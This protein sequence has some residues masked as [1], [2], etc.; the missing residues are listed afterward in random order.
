MGINSSAMTA[1]TN[2]NE[3]IIVDLDNNKIF[4][5]NCPIQLPD[6]EE[7][8]LR[9]KLRQHAYSHIYNIDFID[10]NHGVINLNE[11]NSMQDK[12]IRISFFLLWS[13]LLGNY[14]RYYTDDALDRI[15]F[16]ADQPKLKQP[17]LKS[18]L[19]TQAF[20]QFESS[21]NPLL[22]DLLK[23]SMH[24][25]D[26]Q[27]QY[28]MGKFHN[29]VP[30]AELSKPKKLQAHPVSYEGSFPK[31]G[32]ESEKACNYE[33]LIARLSGLITSEPTRLEYRA[34]RALYLISSGQILPSLP[35]IE[36]VLELNERF[37]FQTEV[38]DGLVKVFEEFEANPEFYANNKA[39]A[40]SVGERVRR[41]LKDYQVAKAITRKRSGSIS[42]SENLK[43]EDSMSID[44][45]FPA[46]KEIDPLNLLEDLMLPPK[47]NMNLQEFTKYCKDT[48]CYKA[49][50]ATKLFD[51]LSNGKST[52]NVERL[53]K[54]LQEIQRRTL[55]LREESVIDTREVAYKVSNVSNAGGE[56]GTLIITNLR[57]IFVLASNSK[58]LKKP[59]LTIKHERIINV[60]KFNFV[61]II[62]PGVPCIRIHYSS[63]KSSQMEKTTFCILSGRNMWAKI[64]REISVGH[65][66]ARDTYNAKVMK[67]VFHRL[68]LTDALEMITKKPTKALLVYDKGS[69]QFLNIKRILDE[70]GPLNILDE[71]LSGPLTEHPCTLAEQLLV[72]AT[73]IFFCYVRPDGQ[74]VDVE[75]LQPS[76]EFKKFQKATSAL[77]FVD[78]SK[79]SVN[80]TTSFFLNVFNTLFLHGILTVGYPKNKLE[81]KYLARS[82][83][84]DIGNLPYTLDFI[85]HAVLRCN[86]ANPWVSDK[87]HLK[88]EE[89]DPRFSYVRLPKEPDPKI[90]FVLSLHNKSSPGIRLM[91]SENVDSYL[92]NATIEYLEQFLSV[93]AAKKEVVL[94]KLFKWYRAEF[95]TPIQALQW[96]SP[97]LYGSRKKDLNFLLDEHRS[98]IK[99]IFK[100]DWT[101]S[102]RPFRAL[103]YNN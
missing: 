74:E 46:K 23:I 22:D 99:I 12:Q 90:H 82:A 73:E 75:K 97:F 72:Q 21:H 98:Q 54:A 64:L 53:V 61:V 3:L 32:V 48:W 38:V 94:P 77:K 55:K 19:E 33:E 95:G 26:D 42:H 52:V 18:F 47:G 27:F 51:Q 34:L 76:K 2:R 29:P 60:E 35:D 20:L 93:S 13:Q 101:P 15:E 1:V 103:G 68:V 43:Q 100:Y 39:Y 102:P 83:C 59:P 16:L 4:G 67:Q 8:Y 11:V 37:T 65:R 50:L 96:I 62:P 79:L 25:I 14:K 70:K 57:L 63:K 30:I 44:F 36:K 49:M 28:L 71:I 88:Y 69:T 84:Y 81:W 87:Q 31:F 92:T 86:H 24:P 6:Y 9:D 78:L 17:F 56:R 58:T 10:S 66:I 85:Q 91:R 45:E 40:S 5:E 7:Q 80:E 41:L 89:N